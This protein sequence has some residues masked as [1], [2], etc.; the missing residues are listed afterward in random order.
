MSEY[1]IIKKLESMKKVKPNADWV[2]LAK[3]NII[4]KTFDSESEKSSEWTKEIYFAL[5]MVFS[6]P[7]LVA[8]YSSITCLAIIAMLSVNTYSDKLV[9]FASSINV[10]KIE[11]PQTPEEKLLAIIRNTESEIDKIAIAKEVGDGKEETK[12]VLAN[13]SEQLR[14][15]PDNQKV[16]FADTVVAK[17][18]TL[19]KN[20][21]ADIMGEKEP[22]IQEFYKVIAE[23]EINEFDNNI[24]NLTSE[25]KVIL[26]KAKSF[27]DVSKYAE[28]VEELY[29]IQ[30]ASE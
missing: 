30:P 25:Q 23:N 20:T 17:V 10:I 14:A 7:K 2:S 6:K 18:K 28:A 12:K 22:A 27:F 29:K 5:R 16:K 26:K 11:K 4:S 19:E 1:E 15:L 21:N 8:V 13:A 9:Q 3:Q 24:K